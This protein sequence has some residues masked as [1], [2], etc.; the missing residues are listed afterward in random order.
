MTP[1]GVPWT[2]FCLVPRLSFVS[3]SLSGLLL[4][5]RI[6]LVFFPG[7]L[8]LRLYVYWGFPPSRPSSLHLS[9]WR[10]V[11]L[12]G[13][14]PSGSPSSTASSCHHRRLL[15]LSWP[16]PSSCGVTVLCT[17]RSLGCAVVST[18]LHDLLLL[19]GFLL[20]LRLGTWVLRYPSSLLSLCSS[21]FF[22]GFMSFS[23]TASALPLRFS[24]SFFLSRLRGYALRF[25]FRIS[26][27]CGLHPDV[28]ASAFPGYCLFHSSAL[29]FLSLCMGT[30]SACLVPSSSSTSLVYL[31]L[32]FLQF[33]TSFPSLGALLTRSN[34]RY[35]T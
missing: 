26:F 18:C 19:G 14:S 30:W 3:S 20:F 24:M 9:G 15:S 11:F 34:L 17:V 8:I 25:P 13:S 1:S 16:S 12:H 31:P 27:S 21:A 23:F 7:S 32:S 6:S 22:L 28:S 5:C 10:L 35:T 33:V 4:L 2:F 29:L